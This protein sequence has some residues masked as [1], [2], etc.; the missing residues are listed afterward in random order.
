[1]LYHSSEVLSFLYT[2]S[3]RIIDQTTQEGFTPTFKSL[4]F[5]RTL[6]FDEVD[7]LLLDSLLPFLEFLPNSLFL[8]LVFPLHHYVNS[9]FFIISKG[10]IG[11]VFGS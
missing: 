7:Q 10:Q 11:N 2:V 1:M 8:S 9:N 3:W 5:R 4:I 6:G